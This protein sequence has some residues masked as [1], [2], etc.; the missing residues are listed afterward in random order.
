MTHTEKKRKKKKRQ[1]NQGQSVGELGPTPK[2]R[3]C[4]TGVSAG[5]EAEGGGGRIE[6][7]LK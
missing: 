5:A 4:V 1:N 7:H 2:S 6:K 3:V